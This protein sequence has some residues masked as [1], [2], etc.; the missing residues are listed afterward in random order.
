MTS[1]TNSTRELVLPTQGEGTVKAPSTSQNQSN[2]V[3]AVARAAI[4]DDEDSSSFS[5]MFD[6]TDDD[7][8]NLEQFLLTAQATPDTIKAAGQFISNYILKSAITYYQ[9][10]LPAQPPEEEH[11]QPEQPYSLEQR[12]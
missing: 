8:R 4:S 3:H 5:Q 10:R 2:T 1:A 12:E 7:I 9:K 6:I 11:K